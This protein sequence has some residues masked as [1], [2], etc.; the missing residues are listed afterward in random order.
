MGI[1]EMFSKRAHY[2]ME[3][4]SIA[5][6]VL[7][8]LML[9]VTIGCV[10]G[11]VTK[12]SVDLTS[13]ALYTTEIQTSRTGVTG[14]VEQIYTDD[15]HSAAFVLM[16]FDDISKISTDA[17][18]YQMFLTGA[19]V[20]KNTQDIKGSPAGSFYVFGNTGY[21]GA[22][23]KNVGGFEPQIWYLVVRCN[24]EIV[25]PRDVETLENMAFDDRSFAK[26]DQFAVYFNPGASEAE[27]LA[28]L[29]NSAAPDAYELFGQA[30]LTA[31]EADVHTNL[32]TYLTSLKT[33]QAR[34]EEYEGRLVKDGVQVPAR[35]ESIAGD[36]LTES[37]DG[38]LTFTPATVV[39]GGYEFDWRSKSVMDGYLDDV[40][41]AA[42]ASS[43]NKEQFLAEKSREAS[44]SKNDNGLD[45]SRITW[46]LQDGTPLADLDNGTAEYGRYAT[47]NEDCQGLVS[48]WREFYTAKQKYQVDGLGALLNLE[49]SSDAM[50]R[51]GSVNTAETVLRCY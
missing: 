24:A 17:N 36:K 46:Y 2:R 47:I 41:K 16:K 12:Q 20:E 44:S 3:L 49:V 51:M 48:A 26:F 25:Q 10:V 9:V 8:A 11:H 21:V 28:C 40:M 33:A 22:Y 39:P 50:M 13:R 32:E 43:Q 1:G 45:A 35:P 34:I 14:K 5:F 23:F 18:N 42:G 7:C 38:T 15:S 30:V 6:F 4:F 19:D 29:N 31:E 37:E 27:P